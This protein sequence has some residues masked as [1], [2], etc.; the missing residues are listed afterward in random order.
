M[1]SRFLRLRIYVKKQKKM[2]FQWKNG[3]CKMFKWI[4]NRHNF[5]FDIYID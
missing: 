2:N 4:S 5:D 1:C 3:N